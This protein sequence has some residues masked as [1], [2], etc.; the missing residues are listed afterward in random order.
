M[1]Q[2]SPCSAMALGVCFSRGQGGAVGGRGGTVGGRGRHRTAFCHN[3]TVLPLCHPPPTP[4]LPSPR[5]PTQAP[6]AAPSVLSPPCIPSPCAPAQALPATLSVPWPC[7][8]ALPCLHVPPP[9][10]LAHPPRPLPPLQVCPGPGR[11]PYPACIPPLPSCAHPGPSRRSECAPAITSGAADSTYLHKSGPWSD[12]LKQV[13]GNLARYLSHHPFGPL[14]TGAYRLR[15]IQ[16]ALMSMV[17]ADAGLLL[18][19]VNS[20]N[21]MGA[22]VRLG[23]GHMWCSL[24]RLALMSMVWADAGLLLGLVNSLSSMGAKVRRRREVGATLQHCN[25]THVCDGGVRQWQAAR[26]NLILTL[27]SAL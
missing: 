3:F 12:C 27:H 14:N 8:Y 17:W 25:L 21:S 10:P 2:H 24:C 13:P 26:F 18:G 20:L 11:M 5:F 19:L 1:Q 4:S 22:K 23:W 6:S 7:W 15:P 9:P 16:L